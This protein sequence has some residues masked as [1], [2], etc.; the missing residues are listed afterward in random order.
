MDAKPKSNK[1]KRLEK[2]RKQEL[3]AEL[4]RQEAAAAVAASRIALAERALKHGKK[5]RRDLPRFLERLASGEPD[6]A[7]RS[8]IAP[9]A[10]LYATINGQERDRY[11]MKPDPA[12]F[13][14]L[15]EVC[16]EQ[17]D[18]LRGRE[19][20][21]FANALLA[22][23]AHEQSWIRR[24]GTWEPRTH[25][26]YRQFHSLVRH[27]VARY[28]VPAFMNTAW[29]EGLTPPG[30]VHQRW[31]IHV[32][33][34]GNIRTAAGLPIAVTKR[35]AHLY[36]QAPSDFDV[37]T[38]FRWAQLIELGGNE[39]LV[40][41]V[42]ATRVGNNFDQDDFWVT[43][44]RWLVEQPMLDPVHHGPIIDYLHNQ[45]FVGSLPNPQAALPGQPLLVPPQPNLSMKG[46]SAD[47]LLRAVDAWHRR[48]GQVGRGPA[49]CWKP[50]GI[51][52][53][54]YEEGE[55]KSRRIFMITELTS[56]SE[57]QAEGRAMGHCVASYALSC[58][59]G[60]TSIWSLRVV[61]RTG[62]ETRLLTLEVS[63]QDQRI[64]Q[65]RR[66][67]NAMPSDREIAILNRWTAAHG[68]WLSTW[69]A[70]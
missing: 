56:S 39:R 12:A 44:L 55:G 60:R 51:Q 23:A 43:V 10:Q 15:V 48:L 33:Q 2:K 26:A 68:P 11:P 42:V 46:R 47:G 32:A 16:W 17:T 49:T 38:A 70:R 29:L 9:L 34:G 57:L 20:R 30:V 69:V 31:F 1:Q 35:Q 54:R 37:L 18:L 19:T 6:D 65:A 13:K 3:R 4:S 24:P 66:R 52:P 62:A 14:R 50:T 25:N 22:L 59:R 36:L 63:N 67:F 5:I 27:L 64:V 7:V 40:R 53:F 21:N 58:A 41:S 61:D 8:E 28:E 45:R